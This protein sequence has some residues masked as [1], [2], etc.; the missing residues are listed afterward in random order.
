MLDIA[1]WDLMGKASNLPIYQLLCGARGRIPS[2]AST[3][4][5]ED[6]SA[7]LNFVDRLPEQGFGAVKFHC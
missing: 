2:Y 1:L 6:V 7:Y 5:R 4:M 3:P